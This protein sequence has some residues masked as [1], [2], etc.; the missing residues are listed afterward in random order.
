[1]DSRTET[2]MQS[3]GTPAAE[4][5]TA[6]PQ[7]GTRLAGDGGTPDETTV[8]HDGELDAPPDEDAGGDPYNHTGRFHRIVR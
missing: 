1:M 7:T 6:D 5:S 3:P 2:L 8:A 4:E